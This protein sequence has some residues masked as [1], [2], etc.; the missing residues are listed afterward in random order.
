MWGLN[1][2]PSPY[3]SD[4]LRWRQQTT[5]LFAN[6]PLLFFC[7]EEEEKKEEKMKEKKDA[8]A[9]SVKRDE[10]D[11]KAQLQKRALDL[12]TNYRQLGITEIL[13]GVG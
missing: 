6:M 12:L 11:N 10:D 9:Q 7:D 1:P 2:Q 4:A 13:C 8:E 5:F 3:Q